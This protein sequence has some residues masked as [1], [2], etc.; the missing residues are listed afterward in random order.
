MSNTPTPTSEQ[1]L[2]EIE[3]EMAEM[4]LETKELAEMCVHTERQATSLDH[5]DE[6]VAEKATVLPELE[7]KFLEEETPSSTAA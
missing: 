1:R 5:A 3:G 6:E 2:D 4:E 7:R